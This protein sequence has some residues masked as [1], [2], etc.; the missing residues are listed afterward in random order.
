MSRHIIF[1]YAP[2]AQRIEHVPSKHVIVVRFHSG[3]QKFIVMT[4]EQLKKELLGKAF[5]DF[6]NG[7]K[8]IIE[9]I[10]INHVE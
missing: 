2:V 10:E 1:S 9:D 5:V 4:E 3:V 8:F 7:F 6:G